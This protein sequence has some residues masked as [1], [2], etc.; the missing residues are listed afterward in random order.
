MT[1]NFK[2]GF[3]VKSVEL[4][5]DELEKINSFTRSPFTADRLYA[6]NVTLCNN[7]IDRDNEKFDLSALNALAPMFIGRTGIKDHSMKSDDQTARIYDTWVE[8]QEGRKTADG[9]DYYCLKAKAYM[10]RSDENQPFITALEAGIKKEVS[11]SCSMGKSICSVCG[12]DKRAHRCEHIPGKVYNGKK[13]F[14]ILTDPQDAY[15]FSFVAVPAQREAGVT[16]NYKI[17]EKEALDMESIMKTLK[18]CTDSVVLTKAQAESA[19]EYIESLEDNAKLGCEYKK[20]LTDEVVRLCAVVMPDMDIET[21]KG[22]A[23]VMTAKEL[24]SFK[25]AFSKTN[26][27]KSAARQIK[28]GSGENKQLNQ[29]KL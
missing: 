24:Q 21:F 29:F 8:K 20:S 7:D 16:K 14:V 19:V 1:E 10:V 18:S 15:E 17:T 11:V 26:Y 2:E 5:D 28:D 3:T 22:V 6:F 9:E 27:E 25:K 12:E 4:T 13:A 23:Q